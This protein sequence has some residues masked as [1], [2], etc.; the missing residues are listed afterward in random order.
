MFGDV[1]CDRRRFA[2][3]GFQSKSK[4]WD[5]SGFRFL[6]CSGLRHQCGVYPYLNCSPAVWNERLLSTKQFQ[7]I[8]R[9]GHQ[10]QTSRK[11]WEKFWRGGSQSQSQFY[12]WMRMQ[13]QLHQSTS[14]TVHSSN[15]PTHP[16]FRLSYSI[17]PTVQ[18][19]LFG[20]QTPSLQ[21]VWVACLTPV[22]PAALQ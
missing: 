9:T 22:H 16:L 13:N 8:P 21:I 15:P 1:L 11:N 7:I 17:K 5:S 20:T 10:N 3:S 14:F 18:L 4:I 19:P 2:F 6:V 12:F